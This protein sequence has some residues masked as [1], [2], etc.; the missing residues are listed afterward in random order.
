M[1]H[2]TAKASDRKRAVE[3]NGTGSSQTWK[4]PDFV[5]NI[6][7]AGAVDNHQRGQG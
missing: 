7:V 5:A 2:F 6:R 1:G 3:I 4:L